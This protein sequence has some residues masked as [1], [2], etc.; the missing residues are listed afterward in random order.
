M[1][2]TTLA[3]LLQSRG[4]NHPKSH[5]YTFVSAGSPD[6]RITYGDLHCRALAI[7]AMLRAESAS[8]GDRA[9]VLLPS[10]VDFVAAFFGCMYAGVIAVP[11][12]PPRNNRN[13][14]R[15]K[16]I[17]TDA[18]AAVC[19]STG[20]VKARTQHLLSDDPAL[21]AVAWCLVD[22]QPPAVATADTVCVCS[23]A[24]TAVLQYTSGSTCAPRG[25]MVSHANFLHNLAFMHRRWDH[26]DGSTFVSWLPFFHDMG[27]VAGLLQPLYGG[28]PGI[29]MSPMTF[30]QEPR[31]WLEAISRFRATSTIAPN[32]A[33]ELCVSKIPD[34]DKVGLDLSCW[35]QAVN[36]AEPI[37]DATLHRFASAFAGCGFEATALNP[38][39]GLAE[40][41]LVV[42]VG[43]AREP[44]DVLHISNAAMLNHDV[45][46]VPEGTPDA[47][48]IVSCGRS[49]EDQ[50]VVIADPAAF[51]VAA[52]NR[53]GEI[54]LKG[55]SVAS[56]YWRQPALTEQ[57]FGVRLRSSGDGPYLRTGDLGFVWR[58][59]LFV[60]GRLKDLIIIHGVN[61][62]PQDIERTVQDCSSDL[63]RDAG[64]AFSISTD[65]GSQLVVVQELRRHAK[66]DF[67]ALSATIQQAV[68]EAHGLALGGLALV[69]TKSVPK[70]TSGKI[71]RSLCR[72]AYEAESLRIVDLWRCSSQ[73]DVALYD[74]EHPAIAVSVDADDRAVFRDWLRDQ[75]SAVAQLD[76][77]EID[78]RRPLARYGVDSVLAVSIAGDIARK[79]N[80]A[81]PASLLFDYP[82]VADVTG[83]L[84]PD[85]PQASAISS[86]RGFGDIE[87]VAVIG[88]GCR[89]PG[90]NGA[91]AF[92]HLL[93]GGIDA[94][95]EVDADRWGV[96]AYVRRHPEIPGLR[97]GGFVENVFRFD[98][99]LFG[100]T[101]KETMA[102]D[103]QQRLALETAW[104]ALED[105][106]MAS[107]SLEGS[108]TGVYVGASSL[109]F[110]ALTLRGGAAGAGAYAGTGMAHSLI[111]N[112]I[113]YCLN[114]RGPSVVVDTACSSS[115]VAIHQACV[116]LHAGDCDLA[117]AG[118]VN[119]LLGPEMTVA[120]ARANMMATDGRCKTFDHRAD[121]YVR[122]EGCGFVVLR[123]L[124]QAVAA[125]DRVLA[126]VRG[127]AINQD[128]R[129]NGLTAPNGPAQ[130][131]VIRSALRRA[132]VRAPEIGY[133][134]CHGTG[135]PL[136]DPQEVN[137][138]YNVL[139][140]NGTGSVRCVLGAVKT[141]IGHLEAAA[142]IAGFIKAVHAVA[143]G[144]IPGNL[145]LEKRNPALDSVADFFVLP[146][147][148]VT[149]PGETGNERLAG[150]SSFGFGGTNAHVILGQGP[151][152]A[153]AAFTAAAC[154]DLD[155]RPIHVLTLS[156]RTAAS[157]D[158]LAR[159]VEA[160][161]GE[162][163]AYDF[164]SICHT[165]VSRRMHFPY[166]LAVVAPD[167]AVCRRLLESCGDDVVAPEV[168]HGVVA[169]AVPIVTFVF[170]DHGSG[171]GGLLDELYRSSAVFRDEYDTCSDV[172]R[173]LGDA[174]CVDIGMRT[175]ETR[176]TDGPPDPMLAVAAHLALARLWQSWG[177]VPHAAIG[178]GAGELA[179]AHVMG[180]MGRRDCLA[181]AL[182]WRP[183]TDGSDAQPDLTTERHADVDDLGGAVD[184]CVRLEVSLSEPC[185]KSSKAARGG[186]WL[187][188]AC[189]LA[190]LHCLGIPVDWVA[191]DCS[192]NR[193]VTAL[194]GT[195]FDQ[196]CYEFVAPPG[197]DHAVSK[198]FSAVT[199]AAAEQADYGFESCAIHQ[200][201]D[202]MRALNQLARWYQC[203]TLDALGCFA[204]QHT[205]ISVKTLASRYGVTSRYRT[206]MAR[207]LDGLAA[208]R[209]LDRTAFGFRQAARMPVFMRSG[210]QNE[211][212][213]TDPE[214]G[215]SAMVSL[216]HRFGSEL[217]A[218]VTG[219]RNPLDVMFPSGDFAVAD[220]VYRLS[221]PGRYFNGIVAA[222][223]RAVY[224]ESGD[225]RTIR[226]L[227]IGAGT[228]ATTAAVLPI[229]D[230]DR[231]VYDFTDIGDVFLNRASSSFG[232]FPFVRYRRLDVEVCP[233]EQGFDLQAYDVVIAANVLHAT[234]HLD[235]TLAHVS[236]LLKP[237]GTLL[238]WEAT[239]QQPWFDTVFATLDGWDRFDD[240]IRLRHPL[241]SAYSWRRLLLDTGFS[242][243]AAIPGQDLPDTGLGQHVMV[244]ENGGESAAAPLRPL[245]DEDADGTNKNTVLNGTPPLLT[246]A[247]RT[248]ELINNDR[249][250]ML[251][252]GGWLLIADA[253]ET[254]TR[255][256]TCLSDAGHTPV[257]L[258]RA[259][260]TLSIDN[261][262]VVR[263]LLAD[264]VATKLSLPL[265]GVVF[266]VDGLKD[267]TGAVVTQAAGIATRNCD[268]AIA[269]FRALTDMPDIFGKA[270]M[271]VITRGAQLVD[272]T[273]GPVSA[274][275]AAMW[276]LCRVASIES[277]VHW[278]GLVDFDPRGSQDEAALLC[279]DLLG[280][281]MDNQVAYRTERRFVMKIEHYNL[282]E[283]KHLP[284]RCRPDA[285]YVITGGLGGMGVLTARALIASGARHLLLLGLEPAPPRSRWA[286]S[287][288]SAIHRERIDAV[289]GLESAGAA[290]Y[291]GFFDIAD[292]DAFTSFFLDFKSQRRPP[293]CGIIH[294]AGRAADVALRETSLR[295]LADVLAPKV[296]GALL[297]HELAATLALDFFVVYS[298][299]AAVIPSR[300]G[301]SY[302]AANAFLD[303]VA[304]GRAFHNAP[305]LSINWGPVDGVGMAADEQWGQRLRERGVRPLS[306]KT[307][308]Q[309]L[310][311]LLAAPAPV[312]NAMAVTADWQAVRRAL[313]VHHKDAYLS[314]LSDSSNDEPAAPA[315]RSN[316]PGEATIDRATESSA[317]SEPVR[318]VVVEA[319]ATLLA[320]RKATIP[321]DTPLADIGLDSIMAVQLVNEIDAAFGVEIASDD[322][323]TYSVAGIVDV[324][325]LRG[326][327]Q[328]TG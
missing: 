119:L 178:H 100:L 16:S 57:T 180:R 46:E 183:S 193:R 67:D 273:P 28:F 241:L 291:T 262:D 194:P 31:S 255:I 301:G 249:E 170:V 89:F 154:D 79:V 4:E 184:S 62:Y 235:Q 149:W 65:E 25:V 281:P 86:P 35:H 166:R 248:C 195:P 80:R 6:L 143:D 173:E 224:A 256:C 191:F 266:C 298:S 304:A 257:F 201:R 61:H 302:A 71:Q 279:R 156:A 309:V 318:V 60:T 276:G 112:R 91:N 172:A 265:H 137:A 258:D 300:R 50:D 45:V 19:V 239:T 85:A 259:T 22:D 242:G 127:S 314:E 63:I 104:R 280:D 132:R 58:N 7:A 17:A 18:D 237:R 147:A 229:C 93:L 187:G 148:T 49:A 313:P 114:L 5:A 125:G 96:D 222:A 74:C 233:A 126:V 202:E 217:S 133:V 103:P 111:A 299:A 12:F 121:G 181:A 120:L 264:T 186:A 82:T 21:N 102:M 208:D 294:A 92:R 139:H 94:V 310:M 78:D 177:V 162:T 271:W 223:L 315:T 142:G 55:A 8:V 13:L 110:S 34:E 39:Y 234:H 2:P 47:R 274:E 51:S 168:C 296:V 325:A 59:N 97:Y 303:G 163:E 167:A 140:G 221:G 210:K 101:R 213:E 122:G 115:L 219:S 66:Y 260:C 269:L 207:W 68:L 227:E 231:T 305:A 20:A 277:P 37:R 289:C 123:P 295:D 48:R 146:T 138:L 252:P 308:E 158:D 87:A 95:S 27:L 254:T 323:M 203:R 218:I 75:I 109:D 319:L 198:R 160:F 211:Q 328:S 171:Y 192:R 90:A 174:E 240:G 54:W 293:I 228:G 209:L 250:R 33:Y 179:A 245:R 216:L 278:G 41:T 196:E 270:R 176:D 263:R 261:E 246:V 10:G 70:T 306:R 84:F 283:R 327:G 161:L 141:N 290:V 268:A 113:S 14:S 106:G 188:P 107:T 56:G 44:W 53:I 52:P 117:L 297:L 26:H 251:P 124:R 238:L 322:I 225:S 226:I 98:R 215:L 212:A 244:A 199:T 88:L 150:V 287:D 190:R 152:A 272:D 275:A 130:E 15:I 220:H 30:L 311:T 284:F 164:A 286:A 282:C 73:P 77:R 99:H 145:H 69:R 292:R 326:D 206:L 32:F 9:L 159:D 153:T 169:T 232:N 317:S 185:G 253:G 23:P 144:V 42:S 182:A 128:G 324:I 320:E 200:S 175:I 72:Q 64:A 189:S 316:V 204:D 108:A 134:E 321:I 38:G 155:D 165:A 11:I 83:F 36:G 40:A 288:L 3:G 236:A 312:H 214:N 43:Q 81:L 116:A 267:T 76:R 29:L 1:K 243:F 24:D 151:A 230:V 285:T 247:W 136:G 307:A 135:T 157:R 197:V 129:S 131:A 205:E 105:A 118:G